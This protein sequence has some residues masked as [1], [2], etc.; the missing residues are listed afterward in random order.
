MVR[1]YDGEV[2]TLDL[3][4]Y[5]R[6]Q[7][8]QNCWQF[9]HC[10]RM[11][12]LVY[13]GDVI[14]GAMSYYDIVMNRSVPQKCLY[15]NDNIFVEARDYFIGMD[16]A[17]HSCIPVLDENNECVFILE[18]YYNKLY[19]LSKDGRVYDDF[20]DYDLFNDRENLDYTLFMGKDVAVFYTVEEYTFAITNLL[21]KE[22]PDI[23][24]IYLDKN[25]ALFWNNDNVII[26]ENIY[27]I[28]DC[29][30]NKLCIYIH[31]SGKD[32]E[33]LVPNTIV[34]VYN[35][36]SVMKSLT[37][38]SKREKY[39]ELNKDK[40]FLLIDCTCEKSGLVDIMRSVCDYAR[41][42][43]KRNWIPVVKLDSPLNQYVED[44]E[45]MWESFFEPVSDIS[46]GE[47]LN[48]NNVI[49]LKENKNKLDSTEFNPFYAHENA[50][51]CTHY[52][53]ELN[54]YVRINQSTL[55]Y[56]FE[57][58]PN[59]ILDNNVRVLGIVMR[60]SDFRKSALE[61]RKE[62][63]N[64]ASIEQVIK[65]ADELCSIW[66]YDYIFVATEEVGYLEA[67]QEKYQ[68][69]LLFVEQKRVA[70]DEERD[71]NRFVS[72]ML[73]IKGDRSFTL[74]YLTVL[75]A[76][77]KCD[78][79]LASMDCGALFAAHQWNKGKYEVEEI[80]SY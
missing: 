53:G 54:S 25:A 79:L 15:M 76:L 10:E 58:L 41:V 34:N 18:Y 68:D 60:G 77:S 27:D 45:N 48:S 73:E 20:K 78:G 21:L 75:Y 69:K 31:S 80:L 42:A 50:I 63:R 66:Q 46:V 6:M 8:L 19:N 62:K 44:G 71:K 24:I 56:I 39:G 13:D 3:N 37:W 40:T 17:E 4:S 64:N 14:V 2:F 49:S 74:N 29:I 51:L 33:M 61:E 72:D 65:R 47:V 9:S 43:K 11:R 70:W 38:A 67:F 1:I 30:S 36:I 35:S 59:Q 32:G 26:R 23:K 52:A 16:A 57:K 5:N 55:S 7:T 12:F 28:Q 22:Y